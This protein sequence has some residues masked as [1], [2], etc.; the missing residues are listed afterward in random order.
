[1]GA[2]PQDMVDHVTAQTMVMVAI[3]SAVLGALGYGLSPY[4]LTL[5]G[6]A[7][8]VYAGA[9][10]FMRVSFVGIIFVFMYAMFQA[11]MRAIG[12]TKLPL[13]IVRCL[14]T[15]AP[16]PAHHSDNDSYE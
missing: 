14:R 2:G 5:L 4:L 12:Q 10:G 3:N 16:A 8:D 9:L 15:S 13:Y 11:L 6:V 7:S 1:M